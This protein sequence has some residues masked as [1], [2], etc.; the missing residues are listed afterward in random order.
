MSI[1]TRSRNLSEA[2]APPCDSPES[3]PA[4]PAARHEEECPERAACP[5]EAPE[6][7]KAGQT[8]APDAGDG[9]ANYLEHEFTSGRSQS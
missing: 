5:R 7:R 9:R 3:L 8:E 6:S 1:V 4:N 2:L